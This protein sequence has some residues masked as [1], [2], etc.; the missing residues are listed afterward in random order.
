MRI[1]GSFFARLTAR[2]VGALV[3]WGLAGL[4][5][6]AP[7]AL[8]SAGTDA[9]LFGMRELR[10]ENLKLFPKWTGMLDRYFAQA[11]LAD[12]PCSSSIF[13][14][15]HLAEWKQFIES[16]RDR[17]R[18][19]QLREVNR[20]MNRVRYIVDPRNYGVPDYWA[21]P[22]QFFSRR[23]DCEDYAIAK[24]M[25][26]RALG[27]GNEEMRVVVLQDLNLGVAHAILV[28]YVDD[29]VMVL[30]NQI[31]QVLPSTAIR[32]YRPIYSVNENHWW[33]HRG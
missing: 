31:N 14:R 32:H 29:G 19:T 7:P 18:M 20:F 30:D 11:E 27:L 24:F 15:C 13:N 12:A 16:I 25:T 22:K 28:V 10:S 33:L 1:S 21:T 23:G 9:G 5:F 2:G 8:A 6:L 17:D 26:L 3:G 4:L